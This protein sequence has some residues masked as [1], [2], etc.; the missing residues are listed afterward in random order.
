MGRGL[1]CLGNGGEDLRGGSEEIVGREGGMDVQQEGRVFRGIG[2]WDLCI[3]L[4]PRYPF[5]SLEFKVE[6]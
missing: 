1:C 4:I 3:C 6:G 5:F 2:V